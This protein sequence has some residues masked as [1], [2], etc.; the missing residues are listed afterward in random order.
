[1]TDEETSAFQAI[2]KLADEIVRLVDQLKKH[3]DA[4]VPVTKQRDESGHDVPSSNWNVAAWFTLV[5]MAE[6]PFEV[7]RALERARDALQ[8]SVATMTNLE[9]RMVRQL[10]TLDSRVAALETKVESIETKLN[11]LFQ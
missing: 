11:R 10:S 6:Y 7:V 1:M 9:R 3:A 4:I 5:S 8:E 2:E